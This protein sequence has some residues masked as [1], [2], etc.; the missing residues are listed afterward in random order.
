MLQNE[1]LT[2]KIWGCVFE[3]YKELGAVFLE[4]V[5]EKSTNT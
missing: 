3:V 2:Y 4:N 5:Y 1:E